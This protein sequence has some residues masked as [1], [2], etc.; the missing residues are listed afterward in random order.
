MARPSGESHAIE[1]TL[2]LWHMGDVATECV[3]KHS[4]RLLTIS[5]LACSSNKIYV[6]LL[7]YQFTTLILYIPR[8]KI[9]CG[10]VAK[11]NE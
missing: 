4:S 6:Q 5:Q 3:A 11:W 9:S 8:H 2:F 7:C 10:T 1:L